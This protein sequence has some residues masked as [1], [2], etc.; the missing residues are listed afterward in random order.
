MKETKKHSIMPVVKKISLY[1]ANEDA[2][3]WRARPYAER[4]EALEQ[5]RQEYHH[6]KYN[7]EPG[8]QR[9]Y[10]IDKR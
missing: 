5:I 8:F 2:A 7:A 1:S 10:T 4:I 9:V 3:Y 6:W